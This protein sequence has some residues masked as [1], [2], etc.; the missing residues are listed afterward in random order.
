MHLN[1]V[2]YIIIVVLS[3][4]NATSNWSLRCGDGEA[5]FYGTVT[6]TNFIGP[7]QGLTGH[8]I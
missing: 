6:A 5:Q 1:H 3:G 7:A 2:G 8:Q 4:F